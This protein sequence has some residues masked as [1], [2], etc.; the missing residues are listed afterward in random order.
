MAPPSC[1][2]RICMAGGRARGRA[3]GNNSVREDTL[4]SARLL[5]SEPNEPKVLAHTNA[6]KRPR[7]SLVGALLFASLFRSAR[8]A[9]NFVMAD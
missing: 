8:L 5:A 4:S 2:G 9:G 7:C 3:K 1:L 6:H